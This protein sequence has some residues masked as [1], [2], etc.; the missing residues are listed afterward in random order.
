MFTRSSATPR[1]LWA[2][3]FI[4]GLPNNRHSAQSSSSGGLGLGASV[5]VAVG[6]WLSG[7]LRS[8]RGEAEEA[9]TGLWLVNREGQLGPGMPGLGSTF[10]S[11]LWA[12]L[13]ALDQ[14]VEEG[15]ITLHRTALLPSLAFLHTVVEASEA[16]LE[17]SQNLGRPEGKGV[18]PCWWEGR[19]RIPYLDVEAE[20]LRLRGYLF[21]SRS[22]R[23]AEVT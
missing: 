9:W 10:W 6:S 2:Q 5:L 7:C 15:G 22:R 21:K 19:R 20:Y 4:Q 18:P 8:G 23:I 12:T 16:K 14:C 11:G 13:S 3:G 1:I 17:C